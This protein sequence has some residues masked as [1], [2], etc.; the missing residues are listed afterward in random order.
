MRLAIVIVSYNGRRWLARSLGS[1][2]QYAPGV[3]V[4]V[5]DCAS[6][7][8]SA[9][10]VARDFPAVRLARQ[11][12]NLGFAGGNNVGLRQALADGAEAVFLLNQDAELQAGALPKLTAVLEHNPRVAAVQPAIFLPDG[13]VNSLGN[14]YH[15]LGFGEA[16][17]N[18]LS[19]PEAAKQLPWVAHG[20]EPPYLSGAAVLLRASALREVGLFDDELF[21]YHEDMELSLRLR[22]AGWHLAFER[23]ARVTHY[24]DHKRSLQQLYYMERNRFIVWL[25][26]FKLPTLLLLALPALLAEVL[27]L[28]AAARHGWL[29]PKLNSYGYF[30]WPASWDSLGARRRRSAAL[31]QVSDRELLAYASSTIT[32]HQAGGG[33]L[34]SLANALGAVGWRML[35]PLIR[36]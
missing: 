27:M 13:T 30:V 9:D 36:W 16:G 29:M 5:V 32:S 21:L 28:V 11:Q 15:Y 19:E 14:L 26:C 34:H 8:D 23:G 25:S 22:L 18:G 12:K 24:Y 2:A 31:R 4:Y 35:Y 1:C 7:D 20:G 17:G 6:Q 3:P 10:F 33:V